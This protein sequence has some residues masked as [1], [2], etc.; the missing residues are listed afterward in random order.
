MPVVATAAEDE[1]GDGNVTMDEDGSCV[2]SEKAGGGGP[3]AAP[4]GDCCTFGDGDG[5]TTWCSDAVCRNAV[6][7]C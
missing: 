7:G 5:I 3:A 6:A 2:T 1:D 4:V